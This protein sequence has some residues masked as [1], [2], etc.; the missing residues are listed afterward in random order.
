MSKTFFDI[1][2]S[3]DGYL[4][5]TNASPDNPL[6]DHGTLL[7]NWM[8][9]QKAFWKHLG[10]EDGLEDGPD[11]VLI[12][13]TFARTGAVIMGKRLF[14]EGEPRWPEDLFKCDVY[15]LTH[16]KR[17]PWIQKGTT[18]Y[19][20]INDGMESAFEKAKQSAKEMDI[21]IQGGADTIRQFLNA[22]LIDEFCI[23]I[24]PVLL[25]NG[26]RLFDNINKDMCN[27]EMSE[28]ITS[29]LTTHLKYKLTRK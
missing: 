8:F 7:H 3:L 22:G 26:I 11:G 21:R 10:T 16:E 18:S 24:S 15:V 27:V 5:G 2:I 25:G 29:K 17:E 6:G 12:N 20:F 19:Y 4:A 14:E 9:V 13:E 1:A 23:H 28:V